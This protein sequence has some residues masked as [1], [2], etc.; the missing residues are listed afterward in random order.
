[1]R[2]YQRPPKSLP[3]SDRPPQR[4]DRGLQG[5]GTHAVELRLRRPPD[6][7]RPAGHA[8]RSHGRAQ[9][10]LGRGELEVHQ[11][12]RRQRADQS[13]LPERLEPLDPV[14]DR[15]FTTTLGPVSRVLQTSSLARFESRALGTTSGRFPPPLPGSKYFAPGDRLPI[16]LEQKVAA[17]NCRSNRRKHAAVGLG[18][19]AIGG[20]PR[21]ATDLLGQGPRGVELQ[22]RI[23]GEV[24]VTRPQLL[25]P[26]GGG[27]QLAGREGPTRRLIVAAGDG[28]EADVADAEAAASSRATVNSVSNRFWKHPPLSASGSPA[29]LPATLAIIS[30]SVL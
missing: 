14:S 19:H 13:A 27:S 17:G 22:R 24:E 6:G 7:S 30:V 11:L 10:P 15:L 4:M 26:P 3:R 16:S 2:E 8:L 18:P 25:D 23:P 1:M 21:A 5:P 28:Q 12:G 20:C 29:C 9:T